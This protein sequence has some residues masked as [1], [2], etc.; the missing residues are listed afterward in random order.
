MRADGVLKLL[1]NVKVFKDMPIEQVQD[2][3]VRFGAIESGNK[4]TTFLA[5]TSN[6]DSAFE[7][8]TSH[9]DCGL[10]ITIIVIN[11]SDYT[12]TT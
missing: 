7:L 3:Y 12:L 11:C 6:S 9:F 2:S 10:K 1:L 5:K 4:L 8:V